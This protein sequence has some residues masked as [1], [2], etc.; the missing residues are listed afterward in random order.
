MEELLSQLLG[1]VIGGALG[2]WYLT[3]RK[4]SSKL[5]LYHFVLAAI[6]LLLGLTS[7]VETVKIVYTAFASL[8]IL[9]SAVYLKIKD[10]R[11][12]AEDADVWTTALMM[13]MWIT[14]VLTLGMDYANTKF[15]LNPLI[16]GMAGAFLSSLFRQRTNRGKRKK[17]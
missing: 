9:I 11:K 12:S 3:V 14:S 10:N 8:F 17:E 2:S 1:M 13:L 15:A 6:C 7:G 5:S 4:F 16:I